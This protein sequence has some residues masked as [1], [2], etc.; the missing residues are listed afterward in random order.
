MKDQVID[1]N[2]TLQVEKHL[3]SSGHQMGESVKNS[4]ELIY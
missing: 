1:E 4:L 2:D 3:I